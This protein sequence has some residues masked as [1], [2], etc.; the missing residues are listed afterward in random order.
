MILC[1]LQE[2][3]NPEILN[4]SKTRVATPAAAAAASDPE[5]GRPTKERYAQQ[6]NARPAFWR[7]T[8]GII[9]IVVAIVVILAAVIGGA[10]GGTVG[11]KKTNVVSIPQGGS[12]QGTQSGSGNGVQPQGGGSSSASSTSSGASSSASPSTSIPNF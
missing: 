4:T 10:V 1:N 5:L 7:T 6:T 2:G 3:Y 11:K 8:K 9:I 12:G